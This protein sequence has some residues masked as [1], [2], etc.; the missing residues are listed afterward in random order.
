MSLDPTLFVDIADA[1]SIE[2][3]AIIEKDYY[4][5]E[6]LSHILKL[7]SPEII[8]ANCVCIESIACEKFVSLLRR[9]AQAARNNYQEDDARLIRHMYDLHLIQE[10][11][12]LSENLREMLQTVVETDKSQFSSQHP[13]FSND[14]ERELAYGFSQLES[15]PIHR[16]RYQRFI[17][18]LIYHCTPATW[19]DSFSSLNKLVDTWLK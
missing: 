19:D 4:A 7:E 12:D 1:Y 17:G 15:D 10:N 13:E 8:Q 14:P 2:H 18:P 9:T 5:V 16:A 3:P 6:L 11:A